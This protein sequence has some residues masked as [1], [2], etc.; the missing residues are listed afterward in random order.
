VIA[1]A[2]H[3]TREDMKNLK[4][5]D[6]YSLHRVIYGLFEDTRNSEQKVGH[7][8]S[9]FLFADKGGDF[10]GR[11]ILF[12]SNR[13]P[14]PPQFGDVQTRQIPDAFLQHQE[15]RF[16]V[17]INPTKRDK[18]TGKT[19]P[20]KGR[21]QIAAWFLNKAVAS[22]GF[23]VHAE[24]LQVSFLTVK[25]F[26]GKNG[27]SLTPANANLQGLLKV[28]D[29]EKFM[30][31]FKQGIGRGRAFGFGLLQIVPVSNPFQF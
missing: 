31:S 25:Q 11:K 19:V 30:K 17:T 29:R 14:I 18:H 16:E 21:E 8:P 28:V 2:L 9:G 12:L 13:E 23:D 15:Y 6:A 20:I 5:T 24:S 22:W 1:G 4:V 27:H 10:N 26:A 3:L 7:E